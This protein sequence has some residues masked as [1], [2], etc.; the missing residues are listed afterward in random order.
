MAAF[1]ARLHPVF[2]KSF[3]SCQAWM[4]NRPVWRVKVRCD[5]VFEELKLFGVPLLRLA[6]VPANDVSGF[7]FPTAKQPKLVAKWT[8][9]DST[10][11]HFVDK[12]DLDVKMDSLGQIDSVDISFLLEDRSLLETHAGIVTMLD[13]FPVFF[14]GPLSQSQHTVELFDQPQPWHCNET[15][16]L[17]SAASSGSREIKLTGESC[18][19][20]EDAY[21]V[22]FKIL[23][24]GSKKPPSGI[25]G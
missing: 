4:D 6:L 19:E 9:L 2:R 1:I 7:S 10:A 21:T 15:S 24:A 18:E 16:H 25:H 12:I 23:S 8:D 22:R 17:P 13:G 3:E 11:H 20:T 5:E 14:L